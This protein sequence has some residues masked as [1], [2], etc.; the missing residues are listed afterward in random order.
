VDSRA[1]AF[2]NKQGAVDTLLANAKPEIQ[3]PK[4][5]ANATERKTFSLDGGYPHYDLGFFCC[6]GFCASYFCRVT[7][8]ST[9][10]EH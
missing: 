7:A 5:F 9:A 2:C 3:A 4:D 8:L 10:G 6:A 1:S